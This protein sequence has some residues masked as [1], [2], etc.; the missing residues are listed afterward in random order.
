[1]PRNV[2]KH[3]IRKGFRALILSF[4]M[5]PALLLGTASPAGAGAIT[6]E[7]VTFAEASANLRL[8]G[9]SGTG[10]LAD[11]FVLREEIVDGGDA[12]VFVTVSRSF[13]SRVKTSHQTGFALVKVV[14]NRTTGTWQFFNI[15]LEKR[16]G[17]ASDYY[18]GLSFAQ[19]AQVN[20]PFR[21]DVFAKVEDILEPR[22]LLRFSQGRVPPDGIVRFSMSVTHTGPAPRFYMVQHVRHPTVARPAPKLFAARAT[23]R[24]RN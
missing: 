19:S 23:I 22:D 9:V 20:R 1:M 2:D 16:P 5:F 14:R 21:S 12:I 6:L 18:D 13:G 15:E 24:S 4:G 3:L 17:V 11:P 8:L 10:T 7:G